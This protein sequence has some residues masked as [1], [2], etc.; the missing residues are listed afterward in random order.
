MEKNLIDTE[1]EKRRNTI[2]SFRLL[3]ERNTHPQ[4][5]KQRLEA[6]FDEGT[7]REVYTTVLTKDPL[8]F[9]GY[10]K[11]LKDIRRQTGLSDSLIA[12]YGRICGR[13]VCA[14]M[15]DS[16]F[17]MGSMGTAV[18]EKLV[19]LIEAAAKRRLPLI[20]FSASG[21]ARM[22]EGMF[23]LMQ[24]AKTSAA[25][26][27]FQ[28]AGGLYISV[29]THPTTGGVSASFAMLGDII[30]AEP[31]ALIGFAGPRVIEQTIGQKL[32][33]GFQSA[34]F[35]QEH[36]FV[37]RIVPWKDM[38]D[39]LGKILRLHPGTHR[40]IAGKPDA[41]SQRAT[42]GKPE[43]F[44]QDHTPVRKIPSGIGTAKE[45][46]A[47]CKSAYEHLLLAR[48]SRRPKA[49]DF[50]SA[51]FTDFLE[52]SGDRLGREDPSVIG[53][54]AL[55][56][57]TPVTVIG[58]RKGHS[59]EENVRCNFGMPG[60]EGY[61]KALRLMKQA[62]RFGRPVITLI[63]TPGAYPGMEAE[64]HGQSIAIAENL[65]GMS[66][67]KVPVIALVTG[68]GNSGGALAIGV[69]DR[70]LM[71]EHAVYSVLSPEGFASIL[72]KD[73]TR[74]KEAC[75]IMKLTAQDLYR[76][77]LIDEVIPETAGGYGTMHTEVSQQ[78]AE[79]DWE[80]VFGRIRKALLRNLLELTQ[81]GPAALV[82]A[83]Y[84][85][86]RQI[87]GGMQAAVIRQNAEKR[88]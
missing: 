49:Q 84:E 79:T 75:E 22:Q 31:G 37:D 26:R 44:S 21:G 27:R 3:R 39:T 32:P 87:E 30:L 88:R 70:I 81:Q 57:D 24:M 73:A 10:R 42:A 36:G 4:N 54:I 40:R 16:G 12:G 8:D 77:G 52:L 5:Q 67:L 71:M 85:K 17:L 6:L 1:F 50:I 9:P 25:I 7:F 47:G 61:R 45:K 63:D 83:R 86:F 11:K 58:H 68:E 76:S 56:N 23:S 51:L 72:W 53:G 38:R 15:L 60:P 74:A 66:E 14:A 46:N 64:A 82:S 33:D 80:E 48:D 20:V 19:R 41:F 65:A 69:A 43:V 55:L 62:E 18:G 2:R 35:Q 13:S 29:L 34:E 59:L 28:N 78:D